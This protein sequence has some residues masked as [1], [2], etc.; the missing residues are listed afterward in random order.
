MGFVLYPKKEPPEFVWNAVQVHV[1]TI[2]RVCHCF[3]AQGPTGPYR[4]P[5]DNFQCILALFGQCLMHD[6]II[7]W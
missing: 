7:R 6:L 2:L 1:C 5:Y 3:G 4:Y